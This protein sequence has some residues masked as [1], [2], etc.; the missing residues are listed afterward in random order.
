MKLIG[1]AILFSV[2]SL[3]L[4][5]QTKP[6]IRNNG[7]VNA[8]SYAAPG[9]PGSTIAQGSIF[10][11]FGTGMGPATLAQSSGF[12]VPTAFSGTSLSVTVGTTTVKPYILYVSDGQLAAVM[13]SATPVGTASLV[14]TYNGE[15]SARALFQVTANSFGIFTQNSAGSGPGIVTN[16]SVRVNG[17]DTLVTNTTAM[18]PGDV[19]IIWGTGL[20]PVTGDEGGGALP[21]DMTLFR[22]RSMWEER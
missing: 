13:P 3:P 19:G 11:V 20:G 12:P 15:A 8:A 22:L 17:I 18:K 7:V 14:V 9:L 16:A 6:A 10:I 4:Q 21:G 5:A 1:L 2:L